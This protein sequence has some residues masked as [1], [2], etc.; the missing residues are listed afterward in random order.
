MLYLSCFPQFRTQKSIRTLLEL[1]FET[2]R[3]RLLR[4]AQIGQHALE[5]TEARLGV[6]VRDRGCDDDVLAGLPVYQRRHG[7]A[8]P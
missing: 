8:S 5:F 4:L 7:L 2:L 6:V 1:L 3:G